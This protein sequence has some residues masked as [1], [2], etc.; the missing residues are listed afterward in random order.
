VL[1]AGI[2]G[3]NLYFI[4]CVKSC[5]VLV[6]SCANVIRCFHSFFLSLFFVNLSFFDVFSIIL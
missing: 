3:V 4:K 2:C 5:I 1:W 6:M